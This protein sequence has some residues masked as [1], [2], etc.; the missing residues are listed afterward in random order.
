MPRIEGGVEE[1]RWQ[2]FD[3]VSADDGAVS[4][5]FS[6]RNVGV[7]SLCNM[8]MASQIPSGGTA[9]IDR[10]LI[11]APVVYMPS[12][13]H[14]TWQL[15]IGAKQ[16]TSEQPLWMAPDGVEWLSELTQ[17]KNDIPEYAHIETPIEWAFNVWKFPRGICVAALQAFWITVR[18]TQA[19]TPNGYL[20]VVLDTRIT[21]DIY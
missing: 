5:A 1:L 14:R 12:W 6:S 8:H 3:T 20:R 19:D 11:G 13:Q 16:Q 18:A 9:I 2:W 4:N 7:P 15:F 21:R 10:I 17:D